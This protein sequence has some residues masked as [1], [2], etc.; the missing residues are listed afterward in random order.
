ML[1]LAARG[2]QDVNTA[3]IPSRSALLGALPLGN[4]KLAFGRNFF[5]P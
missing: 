5:F 3:I 2:A 1:S 4:D